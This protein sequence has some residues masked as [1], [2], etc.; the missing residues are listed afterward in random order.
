M[1]QS[2]RHIQ[3]KSVS[4]KLGRKAASVDQPANHAAGV[5]HGKQIVPVVVLRYQTATS[6][7]RLLRPESAMALSRI[8][9]AF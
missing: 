5:Y 1:R 3:A 7:S 6:A 4:G 2:S 9:I 8:V